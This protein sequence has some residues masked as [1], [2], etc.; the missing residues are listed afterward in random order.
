M[1]FKKGQSGN[2][3]GRST[4][5]PFQD[6]LRIEEALAAKGE[7]TP[8]KPGS[9]R[10]IARQQ[11]LR[12]GADTTAANAIADRFDGKPAQESTVTFKRVS[13]NQLA[14]DELANIAAG[15]GADAAES[16]LDPSQLN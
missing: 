16:P 8:A 14:D 3:G 7:D 5:K 9:L 1:P 12:A 15:G 11:L 10:Y 6:A 13:A 4:S 2:P